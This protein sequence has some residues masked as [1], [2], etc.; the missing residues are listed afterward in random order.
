MAT[1][2]VLHWAGPPGEWAATMHACVHG[3]VGWGAASCGPPAH[4]AAGSWRTPA[5][6]LPP[7]LPARARAEQKHSAKIT[8]M[9]RLADALAEACAKFKPPLDAAAC[10]VHVSK[11]PLD[12]QCPFRL[13]NVPGN[14]RFDV[15]LAAP[16]PAA[17]AP[18][19]AAECSSRPEPAAASSSQQQ[20]GGA[21]PAPASQH[22]PPPGTSTSAAAGGQA[23]T[24][25]QAPDHA[26]LTAL[27]IDRPVSLFTQAALEE[28]GA[29]WVGGCRPA[30]CPAGRGRLLRGASAAPGPTGARPPTAAAHAP[31]A[32]SDARGA[33][34][35][36]LRSLVRMA[37]TGHWAAAARP[38]GHCMC[39]GGA[40]CRAAAAAGPRD[41][42]DSFYEMTPE[43]LGRI[44]ASNEARKK[45]AGC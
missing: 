33:C 1:T 18:A 29:R 8:P 11:R 24:T 31:R 44:M 32:P 35:P 10:Q 37:C 25:S 15:V 6:P 5:H 42:D 21:G 22:A 28:A 12:L 38:A 26:D 14:A 39:L 19:A 20:P 4:P 17:A 43:D 23:A 3:L 27:G 13:L 2:V 30:P 36:S 9:G 45:Q 41:L 16:K 7:P 34:V 40:A